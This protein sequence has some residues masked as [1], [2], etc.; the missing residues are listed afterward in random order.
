MHSV[1]SKLNTFNG[2]VQQ[3]LAADPKE[4]THLKAIEAV[5]S[6]S[7]EIYQETKREDSQV[8]LRGQVSYYLE[9]SSGLKEVANGLDQSKTPL[10]KLSSLFYRPKEERELK[11]TIKVVDKAL[12]NAAERERQ[13]WI[14]TN[15]TLRLMN[16]LGVA[17]S[18]I[19]MKKLE[20]RRVSLSSRIKAAAFRVL[21]DNE[22]EDPVMNGELQLIASLNILEDIKEFIS[23]NEPFLGKDA[24]DQLQAIERKVEDASE[25]LKELFSIENFRK[26]K[27]KFQESPQAYQERVNCVVFSIRKKV[28][29]LSPGDSL[30]IPGGYN[31]RG[32]G[33]SVI[34]HI[35]KQENE[36]YTFT[37]VN[38]GEGVGHF[39][40]FLS[41]MFHEFKGE[42]PD[43]EISDL[44]RG[45]I[46]NETFLREIVVLQLD[47]NGSLEKM[48]APIIRHLAKND[49]KNIKKGRSHGIQVN[50]T[51]SHDSIIS[52]MESVMD[53]WLFHAFQLF[54]TRKAM[55]FLHS[56][57]DK[58]DRI[59]KI[60][61]YGVDTLKQRGETFE[62][63]ISQYFDTLNEEVNNAVR[64]QQMHRVKFEK[65]QRRNDPFYLLR[66]DFEEH[67]LKVNYLK[68]L[69]IDQENAVEPPSPFEHGLIFPSSEIRAAWEIYDRT[70]KEFFKMLNNPKQE[71]YKQ[72]ILDKIAYHSKRFIETM[73][74]EKEKI[75]TMRRLKNLNCEYHGLENIIILR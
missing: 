42:F 65:W 27:S 16:D 50:G 70:N 58:N 2:V 67:R 24:Y 44:E 64:D 57:R 5:A 36:K 29:D 14:G 39:N 49:V 28:I 66:L 54:T 19:F 55:A 62:D 4:K 74:M 30:A 3:A 26:L 11:K 12:L 75:E 20:E 60:M 45:E 41:N 25:L 13:L 53:P 68:L 47:M 6:K 9:L 32:G 56:I 52:W 48:F 63:A 18:S 69:G 35:S 73:G 51:C 22:I 40:H 46:C 1:E 34:F 15:S 7:R 33:H 43:Y 23:L 17:V 71:N 21:G 10:Q 72:K 38:T 61:R 8:S 31:C 59:K 37:I